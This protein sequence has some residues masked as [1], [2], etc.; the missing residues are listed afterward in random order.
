MEHA[1]PLKPHSEQCRLMVARARMSRIR[2]RRRQYFQLLGW[3]SESVV[4][5]VT[6]VHPAHDLRRCQS[7]PIGFR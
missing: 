1:S 4:K 2:P 7:S 6:C 5:L 3:T